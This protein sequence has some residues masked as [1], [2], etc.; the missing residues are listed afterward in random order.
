[1]GQLEFLEYFLDPKLGELIRSKHDLIMV[2]LVSV[3]RD[4]E[5]F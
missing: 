1:M 4:S 2:E 5:D 3:A